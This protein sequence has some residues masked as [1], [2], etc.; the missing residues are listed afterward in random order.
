M[1]FVEIFRNYLL[2]CDLKNKNKITNVIKEILNETKIKY[3]YN[4]LQIL[5]NAY[6]N[7]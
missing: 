2:I 4:S 5:Y 3:F 7:D 1:D 6:K